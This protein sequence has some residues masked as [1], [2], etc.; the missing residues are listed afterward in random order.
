MYG[1]KSGKQP[2]LVSFLLSENCARNGIILLYFLHTAECK[3]EIRISCFENSAR[4]DIIIVLQIYFLHIAL[5]AR[6]KYVLIM[7]FVQEMVHMYM[8][9][10]T[11]F[12]SYS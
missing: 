5:N 10:L 11:I 4:N 12:P 8:Y 1:D 3:K 9:Y 7:K 2:R 6:R